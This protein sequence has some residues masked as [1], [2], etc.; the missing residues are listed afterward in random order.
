MGYCGSQSTRAESHL[1]LLL[2]LPCDF[3]TYVT[4]L[5]WCYHTLCKRKRRL[6]SWFV[7]EKLSNLYTQTLFF[8]QNN[9]GL[10]VPLLLS[11]H[12]ARTHATLFPVPGLASEAGKTPRDMSAG[13]NT[14]NRVV[15]AQP[16]F[17][18]ENVSSR[19]TVYLQDRFRFLFIHCA[20]GIFSFYQTIQ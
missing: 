19:L 6:I 17:M 12:H 5:M 4:S 14:E 9:R 7:L 3:K 13:I 18:R 2:L 10:T 11:L 16:W 20:K 15:L 1:H 8:S